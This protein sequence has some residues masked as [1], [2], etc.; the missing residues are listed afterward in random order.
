MAGTGIFLG[1]EFVIRFRDG[2]GGVGGE[3]VPKCSR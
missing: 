2:L 1:V 3:I